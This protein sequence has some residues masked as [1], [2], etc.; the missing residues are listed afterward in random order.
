MIAYL[1]Y[2]PD[3]EELI[4]EQYRLLVSLLPVDT[5]RETLHQENCYYLR[6]I[7]FAAQH[8]QGGVV[9]AI[10]NTP[11]VYLTRQEVHGLTS[12]KWYD[13]TEYETSYN[14]GES[15]IAKSPLL[16]MTFIDKTMADAEGC[17]D[18]MQS[19][20]IQSWFKKKCLMDGLDDIGLTMEKSASIAS[21][22]EQASQARPWV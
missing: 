7:E 5:M 17:S 19:P 2:N 15:R 3:K 10:L 4:I 13:I 18:F 16:F 8:G 20:C 6:P 21:F 1:F 11:G 22:E 9:L 14:E 12:Y